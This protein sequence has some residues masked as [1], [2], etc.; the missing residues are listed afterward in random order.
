MRFMMMVKSDEKAGPPSQEMIAELSKY[1]EDMAK[2]GVLLETGGLM[3]SSMG[4]RIVVSGGALKVIDGPFAE[5]KELIG[6]YALIQ[7]RSKEEAVELGS[8]F[9]RIHSKYSDAE[10]EI[11]QVFGS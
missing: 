9:M 11:R 1:Y 6:G 8:R 3:P 5:T 4:A 2:A 10:L 7:A